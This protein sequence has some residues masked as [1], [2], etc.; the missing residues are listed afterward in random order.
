MQHLQEKL[1]IKAGHLLSVTTANQNSKILPVYERVRKSL[2]G[3]FNTYKD[4]LPE[5]E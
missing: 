2:E 5:G 1:Q 3:M 4:S